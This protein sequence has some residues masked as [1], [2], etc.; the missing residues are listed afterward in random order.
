K[1]TN[2]KTVKE[3]HPLFP[4]GN[5]EGFYTYRMGPD[6][7][8]HKMAFHLDFQRN[9]V[10]GTGSDDVGGFFWDGDYDKESMTCNMVKSYSTHTVNYKG[11]VDEN[12]IWGQWEM[13]LMSGGF[14]IWPKGNG[15]QKQRK[16][17]KPKA[18]KA[19]QRK[20]VKAPRKLKNSARRILGLP[21]E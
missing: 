20:T 11:H 18:K 2:Q 3:S 14:H 4:S 17:K 19:A 7:A 21:P 15:E 16:E 10:R 13:S 5:W 8:Q 12:G 6:A 1:K 9:I